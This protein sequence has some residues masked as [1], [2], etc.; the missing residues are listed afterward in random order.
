MNIG[1]PR[2]GERRFELR[3]R[4]LSVFRP[5]YAFPCDSRGQV[6]LDVLSN[7]ARENYFY[8][9]AMVGCEFLPAQ[10]LSAS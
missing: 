6:D 9:R 5:G 3:Y 4:S 8:A 10:V 2:G 7:H 1:E